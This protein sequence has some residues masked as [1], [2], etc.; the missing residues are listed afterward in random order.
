MRSAMATTASTARVLSSA[1]LGAF[2]LFHAVYPADLVLAPH[3]H[4]RPSLSL[5]MT[6]GFTE[7]LPRHTVACGSSTLLYRAQNEEHANAFHHETACFRVEIDPHWMAR[8]AE[9]VPRLKTSSWFT[10]GSAARLGWRLFRELRRPDTVSPLAVEGLTLEML[11]EM[12]RTRTRTRT[13]HRWLDRAREIIDGDYSRQFTL[14]ELATSVGVHPTHLARAFRQRFGQT[15]CEYMRHRR[16][17]A[18]CRALVANDTPIAQIAADTGF[19]AQSHFCGL[20]RRL[21]GMT[22]SEYRT[23]FRDGGRLPLTR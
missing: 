8:Y 13:E 9:S 20:F 10:G 17:D 11:S 22:P 23:A 21:L 15:V 16:I 12:V 4:D 14:G 7:R 2:R 19:S 3:T 1:D 18:A 5:V 6:G